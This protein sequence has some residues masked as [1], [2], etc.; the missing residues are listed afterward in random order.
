MRSE[1]LQELEL[2]GSA[3]LEVCI[4]SWLLLSSFVNTQRKGNFCASLELVM[5]SISPNVCRLHGCVEDKA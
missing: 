3:F 4:F 5:T 1:D 2:A